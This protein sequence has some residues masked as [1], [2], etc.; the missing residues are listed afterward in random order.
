[1]VVLL[2]QPLIFLMQ[3][4]KPAPVGLRA[5]ASHGPLC[6]RPGLIAPAYSSCWP[7]HLSTQP[8]PLLFCGNASLTSQPKQSTLIL[9]YAWA[10]TSASC[11]APWHSLPRPR[12]RPPPWCSWSGVFN[13]VNEW[14]PSEHNCMRWPWEL[15]P[16]AT[17]SNV[18]KCLHITHTKNDSSHWQLGPTSYIFTRKEVPPYP[19]WLLGPTRS[20]RT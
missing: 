15:D 1:M 3:P 7:G 12:R 19:P 14:Q 20:K 11:P 9:P 4:P 13:M 8:K 10:S 5:P 17:S 18:R 6:C 16:L 2:V